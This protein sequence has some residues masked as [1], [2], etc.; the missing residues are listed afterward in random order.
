MKHSKV[1]V[2][3]VRLFLLSLYMLPLLDAVRRNPACSSDTEIAI[4]KWFYWA[5]DREGRRKR[6]D[7]TRTQPGGH[8]CIK[9]MLCL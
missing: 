6:Q 8:Y 4:K 1:L 9:P 2:D 3:L 5:G 7:Q